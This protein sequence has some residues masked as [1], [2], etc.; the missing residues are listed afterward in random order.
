MCG[1][2]GDGTDLVF[3]TIVRRIGAG[4][5]SGSGTDA[6]AADTGICITDGGG[7]V[8]RVGRDEENAAVGTDGEGAATDADDK[9]DDAEDD[10]MAGSFP[11]CPRRLVLCRPFF[12]DKSISLTW[13]NPDTWSLWV[14]M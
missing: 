14:S 6:D 10:I 8:D 3:N 12:G 1:D 7:D 5:V 11:T 2:L 13:R 4:E 9:A